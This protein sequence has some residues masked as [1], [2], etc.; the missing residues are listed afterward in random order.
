MRNGLF[1]LD[2]INNIY[3]E[4]GRINNWK[5]LIIIFEFVKY[6]FDIRREERISRK[7]EKG[8]MVKN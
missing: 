5:V 3:M 1:N 4:L 7:V 2:S 8:R 6:N